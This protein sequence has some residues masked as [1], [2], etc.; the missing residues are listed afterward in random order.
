M[1]ITYVYLAIKTR[2]SF[3]HSVWM[4]VSRS[5]VIQLFILK[6]KNTALTLPYIV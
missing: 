1:H 5:K 6:E 2:F 4:T 3:F